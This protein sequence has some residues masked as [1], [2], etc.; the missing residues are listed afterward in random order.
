MESDKEIKKLYK[1]LSAP[2]DSMAA[3]ARDKRKNEL[4]LA[5]ESDINAAFGDVVVGRKG[6]RYH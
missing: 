3:A 5:I 4:M 2:I 1:F 6:N